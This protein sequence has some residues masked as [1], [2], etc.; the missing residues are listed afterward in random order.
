MAIRSLKTG[1]FSRSTQVGNSI[2][3][4]GS[5]E[6]I[7]TVTVGAGGSSAIDFTSIPATFTHLQIRGVCRSTRSNSGNG[8]TVSV[9]LNND[10]TSTYP[11]HYV[12]GNGTTASA[13]ATTV[14]TFMDFQ[15]VADA[16][17][18]S[19]TFG[20]LIIDILDYADSNKNT[21][22]R[23]L[24]GYDNNGA[25]VVALN[26]GLWMTTTAINRV[27]LLVSGGGQTITQYSHFALYGVN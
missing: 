3:L 27:T 12:R 21:T 9:R 13:S 24:A 10:S 26:S 17:A 15:R 19:N 14:N 8:D 1:Q 20:S 16:G 4:P 5:F 2:I 25:G 6:S 18:A 7:A 22:V 23:A 11:W